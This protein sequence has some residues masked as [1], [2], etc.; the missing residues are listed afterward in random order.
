M[1]KL[2]TDDSG[3]WYSTLRTG[4][5]SISSL[6]PGP[7]LHSYLPTRRA[8]RPSAGRHLRACWQAAVALGVSPWQRQQQDLVQ[9]LL[10]LEKEIPG[11][12]FT[13]RHWDIPRYP[14]NAG[15]KQTLG[16]PFFDN[17]IG[18]PDVWDIPGLQISACFG[19]TRLLLY[20]NR[21]ILICTSRFL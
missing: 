13:K 19:I 5:Q 10:Q 20:L 4:A 12:P 15:K 1:I 7:M 16:C 21:L 6:S 3:S 18:Y 14:K 8:A 11:Y 2:H 9:E 17:D